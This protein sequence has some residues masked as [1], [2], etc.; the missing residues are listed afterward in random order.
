MGIVFAMSS[1]RGYMLMLVWFRRIKLVSVCLTLLT[2]GSGSGSGYIQCVISQGIQ[3]TRGEDSRPP[4]KIDPKIILCMFPAH[5]KNVIK[6]PRGF[7]LP[8]NLGPVHILGRKY[9]DFDMFHFLFVF[10]SQHL[11]SQSGLRPGLG[12]AWAGPGR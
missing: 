6:G 2:H 9:V 4:R 1:T 7:L 12:R 5:G 8:P 3:S 11:T 10:A